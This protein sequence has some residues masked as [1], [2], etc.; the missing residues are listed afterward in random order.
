M[1]SCRRIKNLALSIFWRNHLIISGEIPASDYSDISSLGRRSGG[2]EPRECLKILFI[3]FT[4][5][6]FKNEDG[7]AA[8][9]GRPGGGSKNEQKNS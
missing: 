6:P 2:R 9:E 1:A 3:Q 7:S 8:P 5:L 4:F